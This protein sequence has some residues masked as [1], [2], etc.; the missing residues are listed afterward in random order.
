MVQSSTD[1]L[2]DA[3]ISW[4]GDLE[5]NRPRS[6]GVSETGARD[7]SDALELNPQ[8]DCLRSEQVSL[9]R[10]E[11]I[12]LVRAHVQEITEVDSMWHFMQMTGGSEMYRRG[13]ACSRLNALIDSGIVTEEEV[14]SVI[15]DAAE[16]AGL[17]KPVE[18]EDDD[19]DDHAGPSLEELIPDDT[20]KT[21]VL[22]PERGEGFTEWS[23]I[24][25]RPHTP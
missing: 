5:G 20:E 7:R 19:R 8:T 17:N 14:I 11:A 25:R 18:G 24:T 15:D 2:E 3:T 1:N 13:F 6:T 12:L 23:M 10:Y 21:N 22:Q 4:T 16:R 9:T